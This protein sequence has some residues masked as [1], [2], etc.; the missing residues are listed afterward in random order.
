M[1]EEAISVVK[2][3][4]PSQSKVSKWLLG[5]NALNSVVIGKGFFSNTLYVVEGNNVTYHKTISFLDKLRGR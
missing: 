2:A 3:T 1:S 5:K 4:F